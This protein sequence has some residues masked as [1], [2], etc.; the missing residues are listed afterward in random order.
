METMSFTNTFV[1]LLEMLSASFPKCTGT[2]TLL[3]QVQMQPISLHKIQQEWARFISPHDLRK[4]KP[5]DYFRT[6]V[7][8]TPQTHPFHQLQLIEKY[9]SFG[10]DKDAKDAFCTILCELQALAL[11]EIQ[12]DLTTLPSTEPAPP[13]AFDD[14]EL[15]EL[16]VKVVGDRK[17]VEDV[18]DISKHLPL[19]AQLYG[20]DDPNMIAQRLKSMHSTKILHGFIPMLKKAVHQPGFVKM[21]TTM[22]MPIIKSLD[23]R[24][25]GGMDPLKFVSASGRTDSKSNVTK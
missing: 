2:Q 5:A 8:T 22:V 17:F 14:E 24:F 7:K 23:P 16:C 6:I 11:E 25:T 15:H 1:E 3:A 13:D 21:A 10:E 18:R 4:L 9:K 20:N 19:L 12:M